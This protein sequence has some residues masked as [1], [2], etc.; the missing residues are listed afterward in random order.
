[1][2]TGTR[3]GA[4]PSRAGASHR[5]LRVGEEMRH[6]LAEI[7]RR[8][9]L[10][11]PALQEVSLTVSEVRV[12][13]DLKHAT[14][15]VMPLGGQNA[16]EILAGLRRGTAFLRMEVARAVKLR[17]APTLAFALDESFDRARQIEAL[18][19]RPEVA[20]DLAKEDPDDGA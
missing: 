13:P 15:F 3:L 9:A 6:A 12:A 2:K 20:R 16:A 18:L 11:D 8:G 1:V 17:V 14:V 7:F 5:R 19:H 10:R 4:P